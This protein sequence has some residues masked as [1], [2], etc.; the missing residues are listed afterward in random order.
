M[1]GPWERLGVLTFDK[2][3]AEKRF[4]SMRNL[5]TD[6]QFERNLSG[7]QLED[8]RII[9]VTK[10]GA[11]M[12]SRDGLLGPY[13]VKTE[14]ISLNKTLPKGYDR[15]NYEDPVIWR[16]SVQFH[17]II[18]AFIAKRAIYLRS[19]DGMN[20]VCDPGLAYT[21]ELTNYEDGTPNYWDKLERPHVI[22]DEH[23]RATHLS[24]AVIDVHKDWDY[25]SD[26]H[27]SKNI[28]VPLQPHRLIEL[29]S[30]S[31][32]E[33]KV[34]IKSEDG[35]IPADDLDI[36][37]LRFGTS[38]DVN[39]GRGCRVVKMKRK[40]GGDIE[41]LFRGDIERGQHDFALKLLGREKDGSVVIA[42][43]KP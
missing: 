7:V 1:S 41:L 43:C 38:E 33:Y 32:D 30:H 13:E 34:I 11:M 6:Y 8:G 2:S 14:K 31:G 17:M 9:M 27:S 35:F 22:L 10:F 37:S 3:S 24:L 5:K 36:E 20:W 40:R 16:D 21:N 42:F 26:K 4:E 25:G 28:I 29:D 39:Y 12:E 23:G 19:P 15:F 18:N